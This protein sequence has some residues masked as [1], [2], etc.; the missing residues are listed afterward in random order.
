MPWSSSLTHTFKGHTG[1]VYSIDCDGD[2]IY[3]AGAD[4]FVVRWDLKLGTQDKFAIKMPNTAYCIKLFNHS[5]FIAVGLSTGDLHFFDIVNRK[6]MKFYQQHKTGIFGMHENLKF[7]HLYV[8]DAEGNL[9]VW[10]TKSLELIIY[11]PFDCGKIRRITSSTD[12]R[13]IFLAC[14]DGSIRM[15]DAITFNE[16]NQINSHKEGT[17]ALAYLSEDLLLSGGKDAYLRLWDLTINK[18]ILEIPAHNFVIYDIVVLNASVFITASRDKT[19][20]IWNLESFKVE[21][22]IEK[23]NRGHK[24]SVNQLIRLNDTF[25]ASCS[26]DGLIKVWEVTKSVEV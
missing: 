12:G 17:T 2:F 26:D 24:H 20:K 25:F 4:K 7:E 18:A 19:I 13:I 6:E 1:A 5:S 16:I 3:S 8:A 15:I 10:D 22:R 23:K 11:L 14:Q 21:D 9:S